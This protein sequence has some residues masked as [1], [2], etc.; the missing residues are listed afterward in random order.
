MIKTTALIGTI[1]LAGCVSNDTL[2]DALQA[3]GKS[4]CQGVCVTDL[5]QKPAQ[6][7]IQE[8]VEVK[9]TITIDD[10]QI[11]AA[12]VEPMGETVEECSKEYPEGCD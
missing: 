6:E 2:R 7:P 8:P 9:L 10:G 4:F 3:E 1:L 12:D 11:M 5:Q